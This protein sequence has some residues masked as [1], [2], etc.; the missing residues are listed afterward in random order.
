M[1]RLVCDDSKFE[2]AAFKLLLLRDPRCC[3]IMF[4]EQYNFT[5][6][7]AYALGIASVTH[8]YRFR[9]AI[10]YK[11]EEG[12]N[13]E[14]KAN[15]T[16][17]DKENIR[18]FFEYFNDGIVAEV[19]RYDCKNQMLLRMLDYSRED[20]IV[21]TEEE[22]KM[23]LEELSDLL[24][25][26]PRSYSGFVAGIMMQAQHSDRKCRKLID[27]IKKNPE[28][29]TSGILFYAD[30]ELGFVQKTHVADLERYVDFG[31]D[32]ISEDDYDCLAK[33]L[34]ISN[35]STGYG[36]FSKDLWASDELLPIL[37]KYV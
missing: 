35:P 18:E 11:I 12:F 31:L 8:D 37:K 16:G 7:Y 23:A 10:K 9:E 6:I 36:L 17:S 21:K 3:K 25:N 24:Q 2:K 1:Y 33:W 28:E 19:R 29:D 34:S 32:D 22:R 14:N 5:T 15:Y 26:V 20:Q 13:G 4:G 30:T 27:Y